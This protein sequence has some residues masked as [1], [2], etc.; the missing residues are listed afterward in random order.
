MM[1]IQFQVMDVMVIVLLKLYGNV[2]IISS[3]YQCA[4]LFV[5]MGSLK[6]QIRKFVMMITILMVMD[7]LKDV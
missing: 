3:N 5:V 4:N 2:L 7:A 6:L 1:E